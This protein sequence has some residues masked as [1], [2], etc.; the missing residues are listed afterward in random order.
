MKTSTF[1]LGLFICFLTSFSQEKGTFKDIRDDHVYK[2]VTIG[3]QTWM[4]ENLAWLPT[5]SNF[6]IVSET[7]KKYFVYNYEGSDLNTV[8]GKST[9]KS[10]GVLYN[11]FAA[12]AACPSDWHLPSDTEWDILTNYLTNSGYGDGGSGEDIGK[13]MSIFGWAG[14]RME[15]EVYVNQKDN[16]SC[17]FSAL[18]GGMC[19]NDIDNSKV[20]FTKKGSF[21]YFWT[22]SDTASFAWNRYLEFNK[23]GV[24]RTKSNKSSG[25]SIR[26]LKNRLN[27]DNVNEQKHEKDN[28]VNVTVIRK[29]AFVGSAVK[30]QLW[31]NGQELCE[32]INASYC[33]A[34]IVC[35]SIVIGAKPSGFFSYTNLDAY[36]AEIE[37]I[38]VK[39]VDR[40]EYYFIVD[41]QKRKD[42]YKIIEK[43]E[44]ERLLSKLK[45]RTKK[46]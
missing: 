10:F 41:L 33:K 19:S 14:S 5:I 11:W 1:I 27:K 35:D 39:P 4:A 44:A 37:K 21:A 2:T 25:F 28:T 20:V 29:G 32:I 15:D 7:E 46:Q 38:V 3:D 30:W 22:S 26:C 17:G 45:E 40:K 42:K 18:A 23:S 31:L 34:S 24:G 36:L 12:T 6:S 16:N 13:S 9:F 8:K 43:S